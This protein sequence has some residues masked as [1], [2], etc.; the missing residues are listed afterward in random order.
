MDT[1]QVKRSDDAM[2]QSLMLD[3]KLGQS[4]KVFCVNNL[5]QIT[6]FKNLLS[7]RWKHEDDIS[8]SSQELNFA[9][10]EIE[11]ILFYKKNRTICATYPCAR[12]SHLCNALDYFAETIGSDT[13]KLYLSKLV[14][15]ISLDQLVSLR[16]LDDVK[17]YKPL[18]TAIDEV[19]K[20]TDHKT[21]KMNDKVVMNWKNVSCEMLICCEYIA[22]TI[23]SK[24]WKLTSFNVHELLYY[25]KPAEVI[26]LWNYIQRNKLYIQHPQIFTAIHALKCKK[27]EQKAMDALITVVVDS[28]CIMCADDQNKLC[29]VPKSEWMETLIKNVAVPSQKYFVPLIKMLKKKM[30]ELE[31]SNINTLDL[32][33]AISKTA[34]LWFSVCVKHEEQWITKELPNICSLETIEPLIEAITEYCANSKQLIPKGYIELVNK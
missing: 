14:P 22:V 1:D 4:R 3:T 20:S 5:K 17:Q 8:I 12:L 9:I 7:G 18:L 29:D 26:S 25:R 28:I 19:V 6:Y 13:F 34:K 15:P 16:S 11:C 2:T 24:H 23:F 32:V 33:T 31:Q 27:F 21:N 30:K 10:T